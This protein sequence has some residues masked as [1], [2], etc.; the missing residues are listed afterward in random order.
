[1]H[2]A[3]RGEREVD[4]LFFETREDVKNAPRFSKRQAFQ[5]EIVDQRKDR[6]VQPDP[7]RESDYR[8]DR[9]PRRFPQLP[10]SETKIGHDSPAVR[11]GY[12]G[13]SNGAV[14]AGRGRRHRAKVRRRERRRAKG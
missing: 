4:R 11:T 1:M 5:E 7:E 3:R 2:V 9:K 10:Q 8:Q 13:I 6:R 12:S 14:E